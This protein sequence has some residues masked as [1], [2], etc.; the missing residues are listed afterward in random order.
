MVYDPLAYRLF[1]LQIHYRKNL[2][3][4]WENLDNAQ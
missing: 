4:T 2:V 1:C 3:F